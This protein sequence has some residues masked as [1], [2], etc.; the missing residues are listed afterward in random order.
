[1]ILFVVPVNR[2]EV[3]IKGSLCNKSTVMNS[4]QEMTEVK[5]LNISNTF[6]KLFLKTLACK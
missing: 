6:S 1:M 2:I 5:N 4:H 3:Q